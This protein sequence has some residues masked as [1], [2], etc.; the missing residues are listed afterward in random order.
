MQN[1]RWVNQNHPQTLRIGVFLLYFNAVFSVLS[2]VPFIMLLGLGAAGAGYGVA[3]DK[4]IAWYLAV[5][6]SSVIPL[7]LLL[8]LWNNGLQRLFDIGFLLQAV[9]PVALF[10]ALV[11][12][13]SSG[14]VKTWFE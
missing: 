12:P 7:F 5:A 6:I 13:M 8:E 9:F 11:H 10:A 1:L 4:R 2:G 3:N 14:Y